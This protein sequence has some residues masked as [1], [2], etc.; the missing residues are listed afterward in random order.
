MF[1]ALSLIKVHMSIC[2]LAAGIYFSYGLGKLSEEK[3]ISTVL[4]LLLIGALAILIPL[5]GVERVLNDRSFFGI[6]YVA[7]DEGEH[8][9]VHKFVH[10]DTVHNLQLQEEGLK[11]IPLAYYS[12]GNTFHRG[13]EFARTQA[14]GSSEFNVSMIGLGAGAMACYERPADN[15]VY[16]EID[17]AVVDMATNS[18][19]FSYMED[20]S[21]KSDIRIGD[22]RLKFQDIPKNSQEFIIVDAFS[23]DSIPAHLC[24]LYTSPSPRD[25]TLS[26]MP[27]SA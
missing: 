12:N 7:A 22:A 18:N 27:S 21:F 16:F 9:I 14:S 15:W 17:P 8:G 23:S 13:L 19:Y 20:C 26:R 1:T 6:I 3:L 2:I 4:N 24:L 25:A 10:G 11:T 5:L